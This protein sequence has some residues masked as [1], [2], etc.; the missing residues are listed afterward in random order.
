VDIIEME[1][2]VGAFSVIERDLHFVP[3]TTQ[4]LGIA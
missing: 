1:A 2:T 4:E 3:T